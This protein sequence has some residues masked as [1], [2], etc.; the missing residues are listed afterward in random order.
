VSAQIQWADLTVAGAFVLGLLVGIVVV[1]RVAR[2]G[3]HLIDRYIDH[4]LHR[5]DDPP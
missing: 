2:I 4:R 3:A 5:D 1:L